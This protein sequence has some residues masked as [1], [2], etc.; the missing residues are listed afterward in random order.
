[1]ASRSAETI[2]TSEFAARA[3]CAARFGRSSRARVGTID[4]AQL[5]FIRPGKPV[6]NSY[7]ESFNGRLRDECLNVEIFFTLGDVRYKLELL[8][9]GLQSGAATQRTG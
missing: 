6:E 9:P 2:I 5:D 8:A 7:I 4:L 3:R 1:M